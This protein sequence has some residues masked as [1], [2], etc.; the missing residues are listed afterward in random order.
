MKRLVRCSTLMTV[1]T[2]CG[3]GTAH[4]Q[5]A[6]TT[7]PDRGYAEFTAGATFGHKT[8]SSID[9]EAGYSVSNAV[10]LFL[11]GGRMGNVVTTNVE[12]RATIIGSTIGASASTAQRAA[13]FDIGV[14]YR[15]SER[16]RWRPGWLHERWRPY[17]LLG[18]G[19]AGVRTTTNFSIAGTDVTSQVGQYGAV[20]GN[21][22]SGTVTKTFLT[23][24]LGTNATLGRRY[25]LD[26]SYRYGRIFSRT[27]QIADDRGINTNRLQAGIGIRF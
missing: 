25:L 19:A 10:Q 14:K 15:L 5:A 11:E 3:I 12:A 7:G 2:A 13:Y 8:D 24:G 22:L 16:S 9:G 1:L 27:S 4:A 21:D 26:L 20:L 18:V 23:V 6:G 17:G